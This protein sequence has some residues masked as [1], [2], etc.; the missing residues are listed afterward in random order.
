MFHSF[1]P[2]ESSP[3]LIIIAQLSTGAQT[4]PGVISWW[5]LA[6][7]LYPDVQKRAQDELDRVV[8]RSRLPTFEDFD[9]MPYMHA[10]V[11]IC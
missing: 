3:Q 5:L 11:R 4:V 9:S 8:G 10:I 7:I 2:H 6:M 1:P